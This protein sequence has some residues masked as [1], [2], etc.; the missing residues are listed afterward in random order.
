M[1]SQ[2]PLDGIRIVDLTMMWA[3]PYATK[4][5]ADMGAEVIKIESPTHMDT[6]RTFVVPPPEGAWEHPWNHA[7]YFDEYNRNKLGLTLDIRNPK[8]RE[9][10]LRLVAMS[11]VVVEN[12]R[13]DVMD[14]L[15]LGYE[16]LKG[17]KDD[18]IMVSTPVFP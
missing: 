15:G 13:A 4:L 7:P 16:V 8:G 11:D 5:L 18:I 6:I 9:V 12:F 17:V 3:G 2:L 14:L 10:F 1:T